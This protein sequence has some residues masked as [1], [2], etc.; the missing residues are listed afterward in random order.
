[1]PDFISEKVIEDI[2]SADKSILADILSLQPTGLS[3]VARQKKLPS[4]RLDLLYLYENELLLVELKADA[5]RPET[6]SQIN[7]YLQDLKALQEQHK[8]IGADIR[9]VVLVTRCT[10]QDI[11]VCRNEGIHLLSY[12][13]EFVLSRYYE[14]F[15]ELSY[16]LQI[17]SGDY[18]VVR[19]GLLKLTLDLLSAGEDAREICRL[20]ERSSKTIANR[21]AVAAQLG[22]V[23]KYKNEYFLT[24]FGDSIV[25]AGDPNVSDRLSERQTDLLSDFVMDNPFYSS[26]TY[27]ILAF[28]ESVFVLAKNTY[29]VPK[30]SV[31]DYFVKSVGKTGTWKTDKARETASYIFANYACE[32]EFVANVNNHFYIAPKGIRAILVLQLNRSIRLIESQQ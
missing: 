29:P 25:A 20:E 18:G 16:F 17:Q 19:L 10:P 5:F 28:L 14:N 21:L 3:L 15:K 6:V 30:A 32:L 23:I 1:M 2:L 9:K 11:T 4:G 24:D 8:L 22:L 13:P 7:S 26:V 31:Q 27:T 12:E